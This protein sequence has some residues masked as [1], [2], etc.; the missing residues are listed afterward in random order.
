[1]PRIRNRVGKDALIDL[2][3]FDFSVFFLKEHG[4]RGYA[5]KGRKI[6][7]EGS[8]NEDRAKNI[9]WHKFGLAGVVRTLGGIKSLAL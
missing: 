5:L 9:L 3:C 1:M 7:H 6:P 2:L 8:Q 4:A